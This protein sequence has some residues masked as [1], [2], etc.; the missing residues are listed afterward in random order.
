MKTRSGM[1][2]VEIQKLCNVKFKCSGITEIGDE[3]LILCHEAD[4]KPAVRIISLT[5]VSDY[6]EMA[7]DELRNL[8]YSLVLSYSTA[9]TEYKT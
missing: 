7:M 1:R 9:C 3:Q 5:G 4:A 2:K 6:E 8:A